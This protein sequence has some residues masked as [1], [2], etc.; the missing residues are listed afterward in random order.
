MIAERAPRT[1]LHDLLQA[2]DA[3]RSGALGQ[4]S[5]RNRLIT[6]TDALLQIESYQYDPAGNLAFVTDR[7]GQVGG[8]TY[9]LPQARRLPTRTTTR[10][11]SR[12]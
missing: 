2:L 9:D 11:D 8:D 7:K 6:K 1:V 4:Q 12:A 10:G 3:A 5:S